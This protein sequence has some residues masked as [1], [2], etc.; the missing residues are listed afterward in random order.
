MKYRI[1]NKYIEHKC[2][3]DTA[4]IYNCEDGKGI[5]GSNVELLCECDSN[6]AQLILN[7]LNSYKEIN[8]ENN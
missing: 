4:I 7:A 8:N 2:C 6:D 5:Y 1:D 3:W